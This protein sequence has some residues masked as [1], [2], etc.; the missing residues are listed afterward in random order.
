MLQE[1]CIRGSVDQRV[2]QLRSEVGRKTR[3][4]ILLERD[5]ML[6]IIVEN[7]VSCVSSGSVLLACG[8][9]SFAIAAHVSV[10]SKAATLATGEVETVPTAA[11]GR[12]VQY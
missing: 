2:K 7:S 1:S 5:Y 10:V 4:Q 6:I 9:I 11:N 3:S 8:G 12:Q